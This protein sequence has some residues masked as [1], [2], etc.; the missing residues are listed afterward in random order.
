M[1]VCVLYCGSV[2][3]SAKLKSIVDSLARGI[4][5]QEGAPTVESFNMFHEKGMNISYYD[6]YVFGSES[7]T[8]FGGKIPHSVYD[9]LKSCGNVSGKRCFCFV[10][11]KGMRKGKTLQTLMKAVESQGAFI[12]NFEILDSPAMASAMGKRL[13]LSN[14]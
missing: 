7:S 8:F 13:K 6:Y 1:R 5:Q 3:D 2:V 10:S 14:N 4:S 9:F 11:K 12:T